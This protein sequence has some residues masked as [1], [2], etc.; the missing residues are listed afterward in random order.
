MSGAVGCGPAERGT[1]CAMGRPRGP[2][3]GLAAS[4]WVAD[5]D[6]EHAARGH[7]PFARWLAARALILSASRAPLVAR[8]GRWLLRVMR[9]Q[10]PVRH[11]VAGGRTAFRRVRPA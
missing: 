8:I 2:L 3:P 6:D 1:G 4:G 11:A 5:M 9:W 7:S 10:G